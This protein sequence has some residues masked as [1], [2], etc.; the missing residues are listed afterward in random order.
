MSQNSHVQSSNVGFLK[1][2]PNCFPVLITAL[3]SLF[4]LTACRLEISYN[5][6]NSAHTTIA[7]PGTPIVP[8]PT[9]I[10][11][12]SPTQNRT[13]DNPSAKIEEHPPT[14]KTIA[15][16]PTRTATP[17]PATLT[18]TSTMK[19][20]VTPGSTVTIVQDTS[21]LTPTPVPLFPALSS[22][23]HIIVP[24]IN[25]DAP[26]ENVGWSAIEQNGL[27]VSTWVIPENAVGWHINSALPGHGGNVVL[28]GHHNLGGEVF[29][30]LVELQLG[31]RIILRAGG[32]DYHYAVTDHFIVLE[33]GAPEEQRH[34]NAQWIMPSV[35]ER[36]TMITCWPYVDNSHR[37]IVVAK[38]VSNDS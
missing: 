17:V 37:L 33:R 26:I 25:L 14:Q 18:P 4:A 9:V 20:S 8:N 19:P 16:S 24:T 6:N 21:T 15:P 34:Q 3:V 31:D 23:D 36:V 1:R 29:R 7:G 13:D 32:R 11:Y 28:S 10:S 27:P 2:Y 12:P 5:Q 30:N 35:D 38:P 22:P